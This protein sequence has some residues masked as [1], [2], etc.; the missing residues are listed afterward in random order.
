[1]K[2]LANPSTVPRERAAAPHRGP[3]PNTAA[4]AAAAGSPAPQVRVRRV[5]GKMEYGE[6]DNGEAESQFQHRCGHQ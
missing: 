3:R 4:R 2:T 1:M 5:L 6:Q